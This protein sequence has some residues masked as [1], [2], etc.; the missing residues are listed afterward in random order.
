MTWRSNYVPQ[1]IEVLFIHVRI[2]GSRDSEN[3]RKNCEVDCENIQG[4]VFG[5][6]IALKWPG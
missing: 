2:S 5:T 3:R 4:Y 6:F 1:E